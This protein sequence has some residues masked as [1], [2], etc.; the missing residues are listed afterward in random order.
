[1]QYEPLRRQVR[2]GGALLLELRGAATERFGRPRPLRNIYGAGVPK[3]GSQWAKALFDHDLV[4]AATGLATY[5]TLVFHT[6]Q[7]PRT[8]FPAYCF[9]PDLFVSYPEYCAIDKPAPYRTFYLVRDPRDMVVSWYFS[10]RDSHR[11]FGP[12]ADVRQRLLS[13]S[14]HEGLLFGIEYLG[15]QLAAMKTWLGVPDPEVA[16]FRLED[17]RDDPEREVGRLLTHCNVDVGED[18]FAALLRDTSRAELQKRDLERRAAGEESHYRREPSEHAKY[19]EPA[20]DK[21]FRDLTGDLV[22]R[23][24]YD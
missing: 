15:P 4:V 20:H 1:M 5:P 18:A 11:V 19:F 12:I 9:V 24:G 21:M 17:I 10:M 14:L 23:L 3:A 22:E 13:S 16:L 2:L 7:R 6:G 8:R